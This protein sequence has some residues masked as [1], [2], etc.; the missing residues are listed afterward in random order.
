M[1]DRSH[2]DAMA[3]VFRGDPTHAV[4]FLNDILAEGDQ[5]E[6]MIALRQ[7]TKAFGGVQAVA[8]Q[9]RLNPTQLYRT[10]SPKGNPVLSSLSAILNA[11]GLRLA[12]TPQPGK[13][14]AMDCAD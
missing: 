5:S 14:H 8:E 10:L 9:A 11:M 1:K 6:L 13:V 12:I 2:D 3:E 4:E 7:M